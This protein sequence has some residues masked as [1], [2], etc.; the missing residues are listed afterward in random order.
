MCKEKFAVMLS[1]LCRI[2]IWNSKKC[3]HKIANNKE[4]L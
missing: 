1:K 4:L 3:K 2:M